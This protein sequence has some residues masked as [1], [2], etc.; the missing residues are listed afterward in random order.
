MTNISLGQGKYKETYSFNEM[1][2][3][4]LDEEDI[5]SSMIGMKSE[6]SVRSNLMSLKEK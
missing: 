1:I 6:T 4:L 2:K 3:Y 5:F